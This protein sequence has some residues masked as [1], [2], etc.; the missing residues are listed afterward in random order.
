LDKADSLV[1]ITTLFLEDIIKQKRE[2]QPTYPPVDI[3]SEIFNPNT[4]ASVSEPG[5]FESS[6]SSLSCAYYF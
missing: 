6:F 1:L 2:A 3:I 4:Q 5:L